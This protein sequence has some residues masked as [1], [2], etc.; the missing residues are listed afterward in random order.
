MLDDAT[1]TV[2][3]GNSKTGPITTISRSIKTCPTTCPFLDPETGTAAG[4][5]GA[6]RMWAQVNKAVRTIDDLPTPKDLIRD[7]VLGDITL[8]EAGDDRIDMTYL[9]NVHEWAA[10]HGSQVFGYTHS[11]AFRRMSADLWRTAMPNYTMNVSCHTVKE[12]EQVIES[13]H[14]AVIST[15]DVEHGQ[16]IGDKR[17]VQCPATTRDDVTC[18][19][20][21]LCAKANRKAVVWFPLHGVQVRKAREAVASL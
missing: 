17:I 18:D 6:G 2:E 10:Q 19:T 8:P 3:S 12:V 7:R 5:Y 11:L 14:D 1:I 16:M 21:R 20:C 4:C 9:M 13:G 15:D